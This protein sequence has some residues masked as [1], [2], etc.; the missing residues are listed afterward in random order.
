MFDVFQAQGKP[1]F[2]GDATKYDLKISNKKD[3]RIKCVTNLHN[4]KV[5]CI[6]IY[7]Y[8]DI[9]FGGCHCNKSIHVCEV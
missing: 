1:E 5:L 2:K 9:C 6:Y 7:I 4:V 8:I 3:R